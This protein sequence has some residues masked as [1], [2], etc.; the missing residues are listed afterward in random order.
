MDIEVKG[1]IDISLH[2]DV[3]S[4]VHLQQFEMLRQN[5]DQNLNKVWWTWETNH[6]HWPAP[7]RHT[8]FALAWCFVWIKSY[9]KNRIRKKYITFLNEI[10][11]RSSNQFFTFWLIWSKI[12]AHSVKLCV[13][14]NVFMAF[15]GLLADSSPLDDPDATLWLAPATLTKAKPYTHFQPGQF[16]NWLNGEQ[17]EQIA[18]NRS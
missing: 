10:F 16:Q 5:I 17:A 15:A 8:E 3:A 4:R 12:K 11:I 6:G 9:N 13:K 14:T 7:L 1:D 2:L 18:H